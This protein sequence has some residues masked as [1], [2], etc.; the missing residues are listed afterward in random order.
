MKTAELFLDQMNYSTKTQVCIEM[1][2]LEKNLNM[3]AHDNSTKLM[4]EFDLQ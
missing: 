2:W 1:N 3:G 4:K